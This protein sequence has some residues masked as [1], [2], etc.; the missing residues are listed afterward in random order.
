[1]MITSVTL[2]V[3]FI[4]WLNSVLRRMDNI[5]ARSIEN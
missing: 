3:I 5:S 4:D 1:M 2:C